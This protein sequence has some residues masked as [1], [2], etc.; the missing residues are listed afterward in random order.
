MRLWRWTTR[1]ER[2]PGS[3][4]WAPF[5]A[6]VAAKAI[7]PK[8][9]CA[10]W[11]KLTS[12][13]PTLGL[14]ALALALSAT[15]AQARRHVF[16]YDPADAATRQ[17]AGPVTLD[18]ET[19]L[20]G[21]VTVLDVR[22]TVAEANADLKRADPRVLGGGGLKRL[23]GSRSGW[24]EF[25]AIEPAEQGAQLI[26]ALCPGSERA[27]IEMGRPS[28][29]HALRMAVIGKPKDGGPP[30]LCQQ[31]AY[32]FHGEWKVPDSGPKIDERGL[33]RR[34]FPGGP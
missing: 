8:K 11:A 19:N 15:A 34:H 22:S 6:A 32:A 5:V 1:G 2:R 17:S 21:G 13:R 3:A 16:S 7:D 26:D 30:R 20:L 23:T 12:T 33:V 9:G 28:F 14:A 4:I 18:I 24:G 25:Y 29:G 31:L 10:V 27:W